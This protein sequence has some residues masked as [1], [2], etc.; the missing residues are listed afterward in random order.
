MHRQDN[1]RR[2]CRT[3]SR[4]PRANRI[5]ARSLTAIYSPSVPCERHAL[6][7]V[8]L[9]DQ[10][11]PENHL[12][13]RDR[14]A[15]GSMQRQKQRQRSARGGGGFGQGLTECKQLRL[16]KLRFAQRLLAGTI[17]GAREQCTR[18]SNVLGGV[19]VAISSDQRVIRVARSMGGPF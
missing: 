11:T 4:A 14:D 13:L 8:A 9:A 3:S 2:N 15:L 7:N 6:G 17:G 18:C 10:V 1:G 19:G 16:Y 5:P 12:C